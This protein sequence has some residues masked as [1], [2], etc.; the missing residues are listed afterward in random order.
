MIPKI[1]VADDS[2]TIQKV[3]KITL[4]AE[5][6][7]LTECLEDRNL[8]DLCKSISPK[9][10]LLDFSLSE[11]KTGYDLVKELKAM[12]V[13]K[14]LILYGTF[15]TV[16]QSLL[17][18]SGA[19][20]HI[21]KPFE[22]NKFVSLCRQLLE[23]AELGEE[24]ELKEHVAPVEVNEIS[25]SIADKGEWIVNQ[26]N[27]IE[28]EEITD[29]HDMTDLL[30]SD[31]VQKNNLGNDL[32]EWGVDIPNIINSSNAS[33]IM[34]L[35]PI[36]EEVALS[37]EETI[38]PVEDDLEY[39]DVLKIKEDVE[40][41]NPKLTP[42]F[43]LQDAPVQKEYELTDTSGTKTE[44]EIEALE[45][46]IASETTEDLWS[47]DEEESESEPIHLS[48][49]TPQSHQ[50]QLSESEITE[51]LEQKIEKIVNERVAA[52]LEKVA[53]EVIPDLAE[54][55]IAKEIQK[56]SDESRNS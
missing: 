9:L 45:E 38:L 35:P 10:V 33:G 18:H 7:E 54:N 37:E 27:R 23:D 22:G 51:V 50:V 26:H 8:F 25:E 39:P 13:P 52:I 44:A 21:I 29:S 3:I 1:I 17:N 32:D 56:L 14:V 47:V 4:A 41:S 6:V 12:G 20:G 53:W 46:L 42:M 19:N 28:K 36:I 40:A 34:D 43:E 15:D 24:T 49:E 55:M 31:P 11:T 48:A 16:D 5:E 2:L 30:A